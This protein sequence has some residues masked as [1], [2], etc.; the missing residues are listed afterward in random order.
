MGF[1]AVIISPIVENI[2]GS[3]SSGE[4]YLGYWP[5]DLY[6]LNAHFG[7]HQDLL[8]LSDALH[9][10]D[11]YLMMDTVV[12]NMAYILKNNQ[13]V[14]DIDYSIYNPFNNPKYFHPYCKIA[15]HKNA[16]LAQVQ[17]CW[18]GDWPVLHPDLKTEDPT[19]QNM[20]GQWIKDMISTYSIDGLRIA[21]ANHINPAFLPIFHNAVDSFIIGDIPEKSTNTICTYQKKYLPSVA[22]YP[23]YFAILEAFTRGNTTALTRKVEIMTRS[24]PDTTTLVSFSENQDVSRIAS[25]TKDIVV[26][27]PP[28]TQASSYALT[29][30]TTTSSPKTSSHSLSSPTA[31]PKSTKARNSISQGPPHPRTAHRSGHPPTTPLPRCT[32]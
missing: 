12:N 28:S 25:F 10:R 4:A 1:D 11:M 31:S 21:S 8:D 30:F 3:V 23:T 18:T 24:C 2:K 6:S 13:S 22:N 32:L 17:R 20:L 29:S 7:T 9:K 5:K 27:L 16:S 19:V 14:K 15:D 26:S